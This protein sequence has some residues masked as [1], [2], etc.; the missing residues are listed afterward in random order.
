MGGVKGTKYLLKTRNHAP[1]AT[2]HG[3]TKTVS[4]HFSSK[5]LGTINRM[6]FIHVKYNKGI[7]PKILHTKISDK[8]AAANSADPDQTAPL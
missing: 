6:R 8:I 4:L 7:C 5:R 1:R 3:K 2:P